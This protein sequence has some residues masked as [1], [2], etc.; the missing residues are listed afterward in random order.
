MFHIS[1]RISLLVTT[2]VAASAILLPPSNRAMK[3]NSSIIGAAQGPGDTSTLIARRR[4]RQGLQ[5][6]VAIDIQNG[7][8]GKLIFAISRDSP[9][10]ADDG[11]SMAFSGVSSGGVVYA[12]WRGDD[13][14]LPLRRIRPSG[15]CPNAEKEDLQD[16]Y[17]KIVDNN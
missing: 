14:S 12:F 15:D 10:I 11:E 9:R 5:E 6:L 4:G 3:F 2:N 8:D 17:W 7:V 13:G 16:V 1:E